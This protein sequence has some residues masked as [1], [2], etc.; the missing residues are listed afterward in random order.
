MSFSVRYEQKINVYFLKPLTENNIDIHGFAS[1]VKMLIDLHST[2]Q[3]THIIEYFQPGT[4]S[5]FL[6][7]FIVVAFIHK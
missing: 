3:D 4:Y 7:P 2:I 5:L 1:E 6:L